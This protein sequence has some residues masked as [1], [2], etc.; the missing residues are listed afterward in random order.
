MALIRALIEV[1][2]KGQSSEPPSCKAPTPRRGT[3][4]LA[5]ASRRRGPRG[6]LSV[7][8]ASGLPKP[9]GKDC[10]PCQSNPPWPEASTPKYF[11][12]AQHFNMGLCRAALRP[13]R[14]PGQGSGRQPQEK[15]TKAQHSFGLGLTSCS[16]SRISKA[17]D[18]SAFV[19]VSCLLWVAWRLQKKL[20]RPRLTAAWIP[21]CFRLTRIWPSELHAF[22][23][24][25]VPA[26]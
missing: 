26:R 17:F 20:A 2:I 10:P 22:A 12:E 14:H 6:G 11:N 16:G 25:P 15:G 3:S 21:G 18:L 19:W 5:H 9:V 24:W 7:S 4:Q 1:L 8:S 23:L 13:W